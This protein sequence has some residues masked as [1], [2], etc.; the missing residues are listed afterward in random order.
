MGTTLQLTSDPSGGDSTWT[1]VAHITTDEALAAYDIGLTTSDSGLSG[2][3]A[4]GVASPFG[5]G[6]D[7]LNNTAPY[8]ARGAQFDFLN[9]DD[10]IGDLSVFSFTLTLS[11][12]AG[13][14]VRNIGSA[15]DA[16][17]GGW[18]D[19]N[20]GFGAITYGGNPTV[21]PGEPGSASAGP[22]IT[23]NSIPEP[24][25]LSLLGLGVITLIRRRR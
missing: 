13:G 23:I 3:G 19:L 25:T 22:V 11:G 16:A 20:F 12:D 24:A 2:S 15:V 14:E 5:G 8:L 7:A 21:I 6:F 18:A 4:A 1:V 10:N 9:P 17:S